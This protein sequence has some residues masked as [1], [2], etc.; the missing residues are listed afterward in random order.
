MSNRKKFSISYDYLGRWSKSVIEFMMR[1]IAEFSRFGYSEEKARELLQ[2]RN[3]FYD[4]LTDEELLGDQAIA[5]EKKNKLRERLTDILEEI[6]VRVKSKFGQRS[7]IYHKFH[8]HDLSRIKDEVL[9][10]NARY[11]VRISGEYLALLKGMGLSPQLI[12]DL[13]K[14][15]DEFEAAILDQYEATA[16][17][18]IGTMERVDKANRLYESISA[19]CEIGKTI[20]HNKNEAK[21]NDYIIY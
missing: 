4:T 20:W 21:Y 14:M 1:D 12:G 19:I 15:T 9:V 6:L 16:N 10:Q 2:E 7:S 17:R 13:E 5:T 11:V 8:I 3:D 18:A